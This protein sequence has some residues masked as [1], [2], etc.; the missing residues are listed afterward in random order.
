MTVTRRTGGQAG[1]DANVRI[2]R[3]S[4]PV[5][6]ITIFI[7]FKAQPGDYS[8]S[9]FCVTDSTG[10]CDAS[11]DS[12]FTDTDRID[13]KVVAVDAVPPPTVP[14]PTGTCRFPGTGPC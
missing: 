10:S 9:A 1:V 2:T 11:F 13:V 3:T 14:L 12:P 8:Y 5:D 6:G 4:G 7:D